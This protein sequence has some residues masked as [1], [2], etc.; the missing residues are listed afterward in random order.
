MNGLANLAHLDEQ[1]RRIGRDDEYVGWVWMRMRVSFLSVSRI[2]S[3]AATASATRS[4]RLAESLM[5]AQF[6]QTPQKSGRPSVLVGWRQLTALASIRAKVYLPAPRGR[7][8]SATGENDPRRCS[9]E[10]GSR[11]PNCEKILEAHGLSLVHWRMK[12]RSGLQS[13]VAET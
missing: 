10:A 12:W 4:S 13:Q 5:R 11:W 9:R 8:G 2:S 3:R 7:P 6:A 1:L